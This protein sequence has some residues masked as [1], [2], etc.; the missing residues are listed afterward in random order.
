MEVELSDRQRYWLEHVRACDTAGQSTLE[1]SKA[2]GLE[3]RAMYKAR[4]LLVEKGAGTDKLIFP[5][6][7]VS[8]SILTQQPCSTLQTQLP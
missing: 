2:H 1:Y 6:R 8:V 4:Q 3:S 5:D 7:R